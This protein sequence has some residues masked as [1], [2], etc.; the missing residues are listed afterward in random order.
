MVFNAERS[1][2][3]PH[4]QR[5]ERS[6]AF[7]SIKSEFDVSDDNVAL[8]SLYRCNPIIPLIKYI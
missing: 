3:Q 8:C 5:W 4:A 2:G 7:P 1:S 6:R